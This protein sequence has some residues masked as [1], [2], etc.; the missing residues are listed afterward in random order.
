MIVSEFLLSLHNLLLR[1]NEV[2][3]GRVFNHKLNRFSSTFFRLNKL[4]TFMTIKFSVLLR[5]VKVIIIMIWLI[6]RASNS[7]LTD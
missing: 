6:G 2:F 7:H 1:D 3:T 5:T 4:A